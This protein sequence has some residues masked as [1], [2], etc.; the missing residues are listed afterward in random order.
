MAINTIS[1][2]KKI[3]TFRKRRG[4]TQQ[5]LAEAITSATSKAVTRL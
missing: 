5:T 3:R 2:G 4:I 1:I